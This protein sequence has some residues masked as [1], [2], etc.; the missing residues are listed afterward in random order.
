MREELKNKNTIINILL[1]NIFSKNEDFSSYKNLEDNYK[2]NVEKNH[3][4]TPKR[5]SFKNSD[6][7]QDNETIITQNRYELFSD[8]DRKCY[9]Q[10]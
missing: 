5:Y 1:E 3:F 10:I 7:T 8:S 4:E 6:K 2:N 9:K